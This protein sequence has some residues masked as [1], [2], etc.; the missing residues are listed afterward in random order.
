MR[1]RGL[2]PRSISGVKARV[3]CHH[4]A[5]IQWRRQAAATTIALQPRRPNDAQG[6][7]EGGPPS[8]LCLATTCQRTCCSSP[9]S[10]REGG[11]FSQA[12]E[13]QR[14]T[15]PTSVH[16]HKRNMMQK[17]MRPRDMAL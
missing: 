14:P 9:L 3:I 11:T 7:G 1:L 4:M 2:L 5:S 15:A 8:T 16:V 13:S 12:V 6:G 17:A 10:R